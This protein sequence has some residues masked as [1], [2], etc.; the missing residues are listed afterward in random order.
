[1]LFMP[2]VLAGKRAVAAGL[3]RQARQVADATGNR[4]QLGDILARDRRRRTGAARREDR[5]HRWRS[6]QRFRQPPRACSVK[7]DVLRDAE[8]EVDV[9]LRLRS[10]AGERGG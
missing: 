4:R 10:K 7:F 3:R 5:I 9:V 8:R 2:A 6:L 1:M